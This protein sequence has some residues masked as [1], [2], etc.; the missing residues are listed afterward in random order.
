[1]VKLFA[2]VGRKGILGG[3]RFQL[4]LGKAEKGSLFGGDGV[5][6]MS[7]FCNKTKGNLNK[8]VGI[9]TKLGGEKKLSAAEG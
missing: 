9:R 5:G 8:G 6:Q 3:I 7:E 4:G 1:M 2:S